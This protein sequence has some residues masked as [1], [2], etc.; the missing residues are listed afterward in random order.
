MICAS[1]DVGNADPQAIV[2][3]TACAQAVERV[4]M[5][6][7]QIIL[8]QA[9][10][11]VAC[12]PKSNSVVNAMYAAVQD[13][14]EVRD[15]NIP[16]YLKDNSKASPED[17]AMSRAYKYPHDYGGYVEQQYLPDSLK[18]KIYYVPGDNGYENEVKEIR[19][20][21]GKKA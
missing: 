18:D 3:A 1:E 20:R 9:A 2:V 6:E 11:Y 8:C 4:G 7:A 14:H 12:A 21:K 15:D 16:P 10:T 5:P 13:A 17:K 19:K